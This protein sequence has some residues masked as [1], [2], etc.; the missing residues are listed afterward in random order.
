[1]WFVLAA[2]ATKWQ[3]NRLYSGRKSAHYP[4]LVQSIHKLQINRPLSGQISRF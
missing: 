3:A 1:L 4:L 2:I